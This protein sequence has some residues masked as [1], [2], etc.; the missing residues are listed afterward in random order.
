MNTTPT[1]WHASAVELPVGT[2]LSPRPEY[3]SRWASY[4]AGRVL[5]DARPDGMLAHR[6]AVFLCDNQQ[7]TDNCG[8]QTEWLFGIVVDAETQRHDLAWASEIES[9]ISNGWP[10]DCP[11][12]AEL[13]RRYWTGEPSPDPVWEHLVPRAVVAS[14]EPW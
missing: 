3:E 8:G 1:H 5:E 9:L 13:A 7:D 12:I 2:I 14:V 11:R 4:C 6:D 10:S